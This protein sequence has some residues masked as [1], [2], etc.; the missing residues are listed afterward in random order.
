MCSRPKIF[1]G[2]P[3]ISFPFGFKKYTGTMFC[4]AGSSFSGCSLVL[5]SQT[6]CVIF[7]RYVNPNLYSPCVAQLQDFI[8]CP[9]QAYRN[10]MI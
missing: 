7:F 8:L 5:Y 2:A 3:K 6:K 9:F 4:I 10:M 1:Q